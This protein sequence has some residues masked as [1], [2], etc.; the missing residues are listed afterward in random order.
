MN[1]QKNEIVIFCKSFYRDVERV[2]ILLE[3]VSR[4]NKDKIPFY[5]SVPSDNIKL[6][7]D[8]LGTTGYNLIE[9]ESING[10]RLEKE[11]REGWV[12]QQVTK[13]G[14][15][16]L[17]ICYNYVSVDSDGYFI[18]QFG[19]EDFIADIDTHTPYTVMH[20][21]KDLFS[22]T[23][24]STSLLGFDPQTSFAEHITLGQEVFGRSVK[25]LYDFG[26]L[27]IYSCAVW[28]SLDEHYIK[29]NNLS[30]KNIL[31]QISNEFTWYG[32]TLF[33]FKTIEI[34]P[35]EPIFKMFHYMQQYREYKNSGYTEQ[36]WAKNY[37]GICMQSSSGL[38]P[39]Y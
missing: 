28:S 14:F 32:E 37:L 11:G 22:W 21:Q 18:R 4:F 24:K 26:P 39:K 6:F 9:D 19:I 30:L 12:N 23:A 2:K 13:L 20:E 38:P 5:I 29:P 1:G 8:Q 15:W 31:N 25:R 17:G 35:V 16:K 3:S 34:W 27:P 7:K 36:D 33:A 10:E